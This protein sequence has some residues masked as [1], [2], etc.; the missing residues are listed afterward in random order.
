MKTLDERPLKDGILVTERPAGMGFKKYKW[1][2]KD[3]KK[4]LIAYRTRNQFKP[5]HNGLY[6][7][8]MTVSI[9][10]YMYSNPKLRRKHKKY[11][12]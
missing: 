7:Q 8:S 10:N 2:L 9:D 6:T 3:Q 1:L 4:A 11:M 5:I 12:D